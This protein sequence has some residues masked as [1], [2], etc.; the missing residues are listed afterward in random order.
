[1]SDA[2]S[3]A[4]CP[5]AV[6]DGVEIHLLVHHELVFVV[7]RTVPASEIPCARI[8]TA[9][10][11]RLDPYSAGRAPSGRHAVACPSLNWHIGEQALE[12]RPVRLVEVPAHGLFNPFIAAFVARH[13]HRLVMPSLNATMM[14]PVWQRNGFPVVGRLREQPST[15]PP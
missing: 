14:S 10:P 15:T 3:P 4:R 9:S 12:D 8:V 6:G 5:H 1:M 11:L 13:V 7:L 2:T